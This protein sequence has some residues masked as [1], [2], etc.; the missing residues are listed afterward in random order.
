[1]AALLNIMN[2]SPGTQLGPYTLTTKLGEGGMG[3]VYAAQD[4]RLRRQV[5]IKFLTPELTRDETAKQRFLQEAQAVS[6][7]DHSNVCTI[8]EISEGDGDQL[9]L[10][11]AHYA[12][13]TLRRRIARGPVP[14]AE[15]T[16]IARQIGQGLAA[17]HAAG[18]VHRDVKPANII[19][20][21]SGS[22]KVLDFGIAKLSGVTGLTETGI[23]LGTV[24]YMSPEQVNGE[25][26]DQQSDIWALGA[27]FYEMLTGQQPF[28]GDRPAVVMHAICGREPTPVRELCPDVAPA[29]E[30]VIAR[31]LDR[32]RESRYGT[33]AA[34]LAD[35]G[36]TASSPG[37]DDVAPVGERTGPTAP[38]PGQGS[39]RPD[40]PS[41]AVLPFAN[42]SADP[43]QDYFCDGL[44][45]ELIDA[46][47]RLDG[48]HVVART[49][50]FQFKGQAQDLRQVGQQLGVST[51]LEGSVRKAGNRLR[52]NAQL[53]NADDGYHLWSERYDRQMDDIFAIQDEIARSVVA[54]LQVK[55]LGGAAAPLVSVPTQNLDA[56]TL[57]LQGRHYRHSRGNV[58]KACQCFEQAVELDPA[59]AVAWAGLAEATVTAGY[60]MLYSP[61]E[62]ARAARAAV[63]R[64]LALDAGLSEAYTSLGL[65]RFW[66]DWQ[67][68]EAEADFKRAL[69]L[70][71]T[72][73][74]ALIGY[75]RVLGFLGRT[76]EALRQIAL[77]REVDPLSAHALS[78]AATALLVAGRYD[79]ALAECQQALE[80]QPDMVGPLWWL[81]LI[82]LE[83]GRTEEALQAMDKVP[84]GARDLPLHRVTYGAVLGRSGNTE[85]ARELLSGLAEQRR[86]EAVP[87][88][89]FAAAHIGLGE[90]DKCVDYLEQT[91]E[92]R[93][94]ALVFFVAL[95][96]WEP[97]RR[98]PR[99]QALLRR[100]KIPGAVA[101]AR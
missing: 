57:Y 22:V 95:P 58:V 32:S 74:Y 97:A 68:S 44:A 14:G 19:L 66:F 15:A 75:A 73:A 82:N 53:I 65:I 52:I 41:I 24:S 49:S 93:S 23:T 72:N 70:N 30:R 84:P 7:I 10:V 37:V 5:A 62:A 92:E 99:G 80:L 91:Y 100:M 60:Y 34:L 69:E 101:L 38:T 59:Y 98:H 88:I 83:L 78:E 12:G 17:A 56:H 81:A 18:V 1:M 64:A 31:A 61:V 25:E 9:Y 4:G 47:A 90:L 2:L 86:H 85:A 94:P 33:M 27:V 89:V 87:S 50:A 46:L 39:E 77:A 26:A 36:G 54:Q 6:A 3:V 13:E 96:T 79:A 67:W 76:E 35:M 16:D 8:H 29:L 42:M 28:R 51:V 21:T 71:R 40:L 20:T 43:E 55:L 48:L 45:E 11:M 63:D